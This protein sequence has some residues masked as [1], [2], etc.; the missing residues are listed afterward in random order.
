VLVITLPSVVL[1][2]RERPADVGL[3]ADGTPLGLHRSVDVERSTES[4]GYTLREALAQRD[5]WVLIVVFVAVG[6]LVGTLALMLVGLSVVGTFGVTMVLGQL[7]LPRRVGMA[8]GLTIG[9]AMG[10]GGIAAVVL[11]ALADAIDLETALYVAAAAPALGALFCLALPRPRP[12]VAT[13]PAPA[14]APIG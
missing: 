6:G 2:F 8:S 3:N 4:V 1:L 11:G 13:P 12:L 5:F 10:I 14:P 9:L 7:Y